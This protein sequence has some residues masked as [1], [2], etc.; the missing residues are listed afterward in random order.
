LLAKISGSK[1]T[2]FTLLYS[3]ALRL[4]LQ[5]AAFGISISFRSRE[6]TFNHAHLQNLGLIECR[7]GEWRLSIF[8][9]GFIRA[10]TDPTLEGGAEQE[11]PA[12]A[13]KRRG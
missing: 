7:E 12:E 4:A 11:N 8:G 13:K 3:E 6:K 2:K 9:E 10:V 5:T 1:P